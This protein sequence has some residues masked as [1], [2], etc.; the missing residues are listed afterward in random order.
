MKIECG[1]ETNKLLKCINPTVQWLSGDDSKKACRNNLGKP[2][3]P[4]PAKFFDLIATPEP[5][6]FSSESFPERPTGP[7]LPLAG[8]FAPPV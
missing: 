4:E 2:P 3:L 8:R 5:S 6:N 7:G 1:V